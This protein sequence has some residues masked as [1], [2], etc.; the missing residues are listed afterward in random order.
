VEV[1][2]LAHL[3][4]R[5]AAEKIHKFLTFWP[6]V[7]LVG[8]RQTGKSTLISKMLASG[9]CVSFDDLEARLECRSSPKTFLARQE[10]PVII[11]EV[12]KAPE[13][14]DA[15]KLAVDT[16][17][18][19]GEFILTG[20]TS[21]SARAGIKESLTGRIGI[22]HLRP[23]TFAEANQHE[24]I[25][26]ESLVNNIDAHKPRFSSGEIAKAL[27]KGGMPGAMFIREKDN[28]EMYWSSWL[29]TTLT[30][31]LP[32]L[33]KRGYDP[34]IAL[35]LLEKMATLLKEG[36]L[37]SLHHFS[38]SARVLRNYFDAMQQIFMLDRVSCHAAGT[39]KEIWLF[40][41][42]G[43]A[44]YLMKN[45]A[46]VAAQ[47][48]LARHFLHNEWRVHQSFQNDLSVYSY[49][50][51]AQG[52]PIDTVIQNVPILITADAKELSTRLSWVERPIRGAMKKLGSKTGI[53]AGPV[54]YII[55]GSENNG[56]SIV[57]W[58]AW[59]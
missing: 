3:R 27:P 58:S 7:G 11:D 37:P 40:A 36:E 6:V 16:K 8:M 50:K 4:T 20:S 14:F 31:D 46:G 18:I 56:V 43:L 29:E 52:T 15:I 38:Q 2:L 45:T 44:A 42:S 9:P 10:R 35:S 33:F 41:D 23:L 13:I 25:K 55:R 21:F 54:D 51:T 30:R 22:C 34:D 26:F 17:R 53:I 5:F 19:P 59:S 32:P 49:Y 39:G 12:Q 47:N 24:R 48:S 1:S 28:L 57:P